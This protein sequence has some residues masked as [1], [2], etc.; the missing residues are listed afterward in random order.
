M[1]GT[2]RDQS[3][4]QDEFNEYY[5]HISASIGRGYVDDDRYFELMMNNAW[6]FDNK[7]YQKG[8]SADQTSPAK[9]SRYL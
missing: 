7:T 5:N 6:N 1:G 8:W 3:V 2:G 4:T 9:K